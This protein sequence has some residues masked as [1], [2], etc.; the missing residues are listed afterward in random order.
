[1]RWPGAP[2]GGE[3]SAA[4]LRDERSEKRDA[5]LVGLALGLPAPPVASRTAAGSGTGDRL[6][7]DWTATAGEGGRDGGAPDGLGGTG[8]GA[9][10]GVGVGAGLGTGTGAARAVEEASMAH[11]AVSLNGPGRWVVDTRRW[12]KGT[13]GWAMGTER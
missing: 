13:M 1:M 11:S 9:G 12:V 7:G 5:V 3:R 10:V 2:T 6:S 4:L 8:P